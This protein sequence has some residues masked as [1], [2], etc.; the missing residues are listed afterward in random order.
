MLLGLIQVFISVH[1]RHLQQKE[2]EEREPSRFLSYFF[3][4]RLPFRVGTSVHS[5]SIFTSEEGA[6]VVAGSGD[7]WTAG[8]GVAVER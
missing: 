8:A 7:G 2:A 1:N 4:P 5:S 3:P 6:G